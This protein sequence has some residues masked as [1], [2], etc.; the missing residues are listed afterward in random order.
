MEKWYGKNCKVGIL[1]GG[2]LGR[3][4]LQKAPDW[5][6]QI[7]VLDPAPDA[8]CK[9]LA[10]HFTCG[11]WRDYD[12]V[13][14]FAGDLDIVTVEIEHINV[15]ALFDLE[16]QGVKVYPQPEVLAAIQDKGLQKEFYEQHNIPTAPFHLHQAEDKVPEMPFV[17]KMRKGG[18]D[19][20]GV[21]VVRTEAQINQMFEVPSVIEKLIPFEK[22]LSVIVARNV[23]GEMKTFPLVEQE[24]N[25]DANLVEFLF[26]PAM[27]DEKIAE[28][29]QQIAKD[30]AEAFNLVGLLAVEL[31]LTAEGNLL[32][33]EAAP[34]PHNSGHHTIEAGYTSQFEQHLRAILNLPLGDTSQQKAAVMV[35]LLGA[36]DHTGTPYY[37]NL[38]WA[39]AQPGVFPHIYGKS[40][41][42]PFRK[43]GHVTVVHEEIEEAKKLA[44]EVL[45]KVKVVTQD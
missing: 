9:D 28:K 41:T 45:D 44:R 23:E 21:Q 40:M 34:R 29:A 35:N 4:I 2:Q 8:P 31:F 24:F 15:K 33:N 20:K 27:V 18:Y 22:E 25:E 5:D 36:P 19:G 14:A 12:T 16:A 11:D 26:A 38:E 17:Q 3:M 6:V 1:G 7:H 37:E 42:K 10:H 39:L 32:V 43:M 30:V 13:M